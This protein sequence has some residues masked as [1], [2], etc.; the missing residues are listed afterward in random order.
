MGD[1]VITLLRHL[2]FVDDY[3]ICMFASLDKA[4]HLFVRRLLNDRGTREA[5]LEICGSPQLDDQDD[6]FVE[7]ERCGRRWDGQAQCDCWQVLS[8]SSDGED[9]AGHVDD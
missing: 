8:M 9:E 6:F 5:P 4:S 3:H 2:M 1:F 7:C